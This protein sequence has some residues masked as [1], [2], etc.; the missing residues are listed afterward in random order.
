MHK[1]MKI[2]VKFDKILLKFPP[3]GVWPAGRLHGGKG[4]RGELSKNFVKSSSNFSKIFINCCIQYSIFQHFSKSTNFCK[5]LQKILQ[6]ICGFLKNLQKF[7]K[8]AKKYQNC[9]KFCNFL[10]EICRICSRED[11]FLVDFEKC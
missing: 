8:F 3:F 11:A 6:K 2:L 10:A 1:F 9:A 5:I 7:A 4:E